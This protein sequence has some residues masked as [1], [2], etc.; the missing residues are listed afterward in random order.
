MIDEV[1][2][3]DN[4]HTDGDKGVRTMLGGEDALHHILTCAVYEVAY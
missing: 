2:G 1:A 3:Q 4:W